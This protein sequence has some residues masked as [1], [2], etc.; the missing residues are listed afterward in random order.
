M[1]HCRKCAMKEKYRGIE[2]KLIFLKYQNASFQ[3]N[4]Q[5]MY[6]FL[7]HSYFNM[8][9]PQASSPYGEGGLNFL[10]G[11]QTKHLTGLR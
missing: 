9:N 11:L 5:K 4:C 8:F 7:R 6:Y 10:K 1:D 2:S 3:S